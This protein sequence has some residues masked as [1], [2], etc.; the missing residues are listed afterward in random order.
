MNK[1]FLMCSLFA[2]ILILNSCKKDPP[3]AKFTMD[4]A[5]FKMAEAIKF[6][7][8]S[9]N[10]DSYA[11]DFGDGKK[12]TDENPSHTYGSAGSFT[13]KL[14]ATGAA[15]VDST[16]QTITVLQNLTGMWRKTLSFGGQFGINGTMNLIQ[17]ED[18]TLSGSYVYEDGAGSFTLR[19]TS[20][21]EGNAVTIEWNEMT[22]KFRGTV[23]TAG[24]S[25]GGDIL[26]DATPAGTW[27]AKRL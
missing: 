3:V 14:T 24:T 5:T 25:M 22:Y 15:G 2:G 18:N 8:Q 20:K 11:W 23:N 10:A 16:S 21:I 4:K 9:E 26:F 7:N 6:T 19:S 1:F 27:T 17:H 13:I 12:S